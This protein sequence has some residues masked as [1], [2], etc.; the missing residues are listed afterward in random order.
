MSGHEV[1]WHWVKGHSGHPEN[2]RADQLANQ[3]IDEMEQQ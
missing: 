3:G 2:E 1:H